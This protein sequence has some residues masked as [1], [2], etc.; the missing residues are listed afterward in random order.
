MHKLVVK[1][2]KILCK[3]SQKKR[4]IDMNSLINNRINRKKISLKNDIDYRM[5]KCKHINIESIFRNYKNNQQR[6]YSNN[7][8]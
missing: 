6:I 7:I 1:E 5:V 8:L 2:K 4:I 3:K